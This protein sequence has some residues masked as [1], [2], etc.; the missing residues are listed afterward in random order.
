M[1]ESISCPETT[2]K[3][4]TDPTTSRVRTV[5]GN[6]FPRKCACD[7]GF[8]IPRDPEVRYVVDFGGPR[9]FRAYLRE[10]LPDYGTHQG[11]PRAH[12]DAH[13]L[14][15]FTPARELPLPRPPSPTKPPAA[16]R[17][18]IEVAHE[19]AEATPGPEA[20]RGWAFSQLVLNPGSFESLRAGFASYARQGETERDLRAR[21][22]ST[23]L[24]DV[25]QQVMALRALHAKLR[26]LDAGENFGGVI[27]RARPSSG[28]RPSRKR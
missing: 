21:V 27:A 1:Q 24:A 22:H 9:P 4:P 17:P 26:D 3:T 20:G 7:C 16:P 11:K 19:D 12:E 25:E 14:P 5:T 8:Q 6:R 28:G 2:S 15:G 23:V 10:H 18:S 13:S